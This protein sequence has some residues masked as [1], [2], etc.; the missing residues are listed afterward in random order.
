M[1][2][3]LALKVY[4]RAAGCS[5][6][7]LKR[8]GH[9]LGALYDRAKECRLDHTGSRNFV[10]RVLGANYQTRAFAYP[11]QRMLTVIALSAATDGR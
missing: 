3:E 4:I 7:E 5:T 6:Q 9:D 11:K 10:L 2:T 8:L 1:S